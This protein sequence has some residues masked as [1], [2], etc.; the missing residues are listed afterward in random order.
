[1]EGLK[2]AEDNLDRPMQ[3]HLMR[4]Y[5]SAQRMGK[6]LVNCHEKD[7]LP[8]CAYCANPDPEI[9]SIRKESSSDDVLTFV[10]KCRSCGK[11]DWPGAL[12]KDLL[13]ILN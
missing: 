3:N 7:P 4:I 11:E 2:Q 9:M 6:F 12:K 8:G 5:L 10:V 1:M 13:A